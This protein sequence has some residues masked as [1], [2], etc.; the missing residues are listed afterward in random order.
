MSTR[1]APAGRSPAPRA[2]KQP[3]TLTH[4]AAE[5]IRAMIV[6]GD[7]QPGEALSEFALAAE[8]GV[9][10]TPVREALLQLRLEGLVDIQPRR[11][12]F[13]FQMTPVQVR[14]LSEMREVLELAALRLAMERHPKRLA[15]LLEALLPQMAQAVA[16]AEFTHYRQLDRRFHQTIAELSGNAYLVDAYT[17]IAWRIQTLRNRLSRDAE[18]NRSSL[19][20]HTRLLERIVARDA[21]GAR[22]LLAKHIGHTRE[23]YICVL[24]AASP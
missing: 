8:L 22:D 9:S 12:T 23:R 19:E 2:L 14:E 16:A 20:E 17:A 1:P 13:V 6:D 24:P 15:S 21:A 5:V 3:K 4:Q 18:L 7:L 10:K 11:G